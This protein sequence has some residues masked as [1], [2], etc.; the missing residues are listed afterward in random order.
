MRKSGACPKCGSTEVLIGAELSD[1]G[2][3]DMRHPAAVRVYEKPEALIFKGVHD[4]EVAADICMS[5]GFT[6]L[7]VN[8]P[9]KLYA[10]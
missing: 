6:E 4:A 7:Y 2:D 8:N 3:G 10:R 1:R 5:C 9:A